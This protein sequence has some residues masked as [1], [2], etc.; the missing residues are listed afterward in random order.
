MSGITHVMCIQK[1]SLV[2]FNL[3][4]VS[5]EELEYCQLLR[6][7]EKID[8]LEKRKESE[9]ITDFFENLCNKK[10]GL[11]REYLLQDI[12]ASFMELKRKGYLDTEYNCELPLDEKHVTEM[13]IEIRTRKI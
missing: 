12:L 7:C 4:E 2:I 5:E 3:A 8:K 9:N 13:S 1:E 10:R 6:Y 11:S